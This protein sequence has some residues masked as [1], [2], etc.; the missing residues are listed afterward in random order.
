AGEHWHQRHSD[1]PHPECTNWIA[2]RS[3]AEK[4]HPSFAGSPS[5]WLNSAP[6]SVAPPP[7]HVQ[8]APASIPDPLP[9]FRYPPVAR[10]Y[11]LCCLYPCTSA[12]NNRSCGHRSALR[13]MP[14]EWMATGAP[15][16][17][18]RLMGGPRRRWE[19]LSLQFPSRVHGF[20]TAS[21]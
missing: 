18:A 17:Q 3:P 10:L 21:C 13:Y 9:G 4:P 11:L 12:A 15:I 16:A 2:H 7:D 6:I 1:L 19:L 14:A 8:R 20:L 5:A